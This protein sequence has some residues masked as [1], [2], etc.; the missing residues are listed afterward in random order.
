MWLDRRILGLV[1]L[2]IFLG[3]EISAVEPDE[4]LADP[5]LEQRAREISKNLRCLV[6]QNESVD[7]SGAPLAKDLRV[8]VREQIVAGQSDEAIY[9]F[10]EERYGQFALFMPRRSLANLPLF[11]SGPVL[12]AIG[13]LIAWRFVRVQRQPVAG[14]QED[15]NEDEK[16]HLARL[17]ASNQSDEL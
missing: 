11:L 5:K 4:I 2:V 7:E 1:A 13:F 9:A 12:L 6:C 15:L 17:H 10:V 16:R 8:L 14:S 3:G